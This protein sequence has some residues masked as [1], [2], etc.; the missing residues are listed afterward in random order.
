MSDV[1]APSAPPPAAP[2]APQQAEVPI[3]QSPVSSP[4]PIGP[5]APP[6][7]TQPGEKPTG[8]TESRR[9][10]LQKAFDKNR[11][12]NP[13][14]P[15]EAKKGDNNPPE[16]TPDEDFSLKKRPSGDQPRDRG[17]F[18][19]KT[20]PE[21][22]SPQPAGVEAGRQEAARPGTQPVA[23]PYVPPPGSPAHHHPLPRMS[24]RAAAMWDKVPDEVRA[25]AH[26]MYRE[27]DQAFRK[28]KGA[29]DYM[30]SIAPYV[31]MAHEQGTNLQRVLENHV[32]I[33]EKLRTD[34]LGGFEVIAH[35]LNLH[36]PDG[37][38]LTFAD[39]AYDYLNRSP[40]QRQLVQQRNAATA[41][42]M[43]LQMQQQRIEALE[44][45][46]RQAQDAARYQAGRGAVDQ[47]ADRH[48]D[49][50]RL[51]PLIH[52]EVQLGFDLDTAYRRAQLLAGTTAPQTRT[53]TTAAQ[54]RAPDKSISGGPS[55]APNGAARNGKPAPTRRASLEHAFNHVK[56]GL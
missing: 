19:P 41:H 44:N 12:D 52:R 14:K 50:D 24:P 54:T 16:E 25:D 21:T 22:A 4:N 7:P 26:R 10:S 31:K 43:Q 32:G 45:Q 39:I 37:Q 3:N 18:A 34:P 35:N 33:E 51:G 23:S 20:T 42:Q 6:A 53:D 1:S 38:K 48:P 17:R 2:A 9:E 49:F 55:G 13:P 8:R 27:V 56:G 47:Y 46:I 5:Q 28:Y 15:R 30:Q 11:V 29:H 36:T 40:E